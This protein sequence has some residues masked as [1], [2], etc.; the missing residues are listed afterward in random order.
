MTVSIILLRCLRVA[1]GSAPRSWAPTIVEEALMNVRQHSG[2]PTA[3]VSIQH[4]PGSAG[5]GVVVAIEDSGRGMPW[6]INMAALVQRVTA[7]TAG[8]GLGLARMRERVHRIGGTL[9]IR[10]ANSRT[11]VRAYIPV[12][13]E[14]APVG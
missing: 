12:S 8:W 1:L 11:I 10:S 3:R 13:R 9:E 2:S 6:M 4:D 5:D 14:Q 7:P